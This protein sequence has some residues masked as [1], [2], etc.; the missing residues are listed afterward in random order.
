MRWLA[1]LL[2]VL[3]GLAS[4]GRAEAG[5][6]DEAR[7]RFE[8]GLGLF[9]QSAW[10]EALA[11][12]MESRRLHPTRSATRN[13]AL[14]YRKL[15]R[16]DAALA[17]YEELLESQKLSGDERRQYRAEA[18]EIAALVGTLVVRTDEAG[19][20]ISIDGL[21][22]GATPSEPLRVPAGA[23]V[24]QLYKEGYTPHRVEVLVPG[25]KQ[26][27]VRGELRP[28]GQSG[29][30]RISETRGAVS[31]VLVD[32]A[33]VGRTPWEGALPVGAHSVVLRAEPPLGTQPV[34][35]AVRLGELTR[36]TV[37][38]EPLTAE[39]RIEP[40]PAGAR[41]KLD[42]VPLGH[43]A[44]QGRV[45]KGA[46]LVEVD[47]RG[48]VSLERRVSLGEGASELVEVVLQRE[49][50]KPSAAPSRGAL[51]LEL[52]GGVPL[53]ASL[54]G[55][56]LEAPCAAPCSRSPAF[57]ALAQGHVGYR[58]EDG[59]SLGG[60]VGF[61][62]LRQS[63]SRRPSVLLER[64][65][66]LRRDAGVVD[67]EVSAQAFVLGATLGLERG[68]TLVGRGRLGVGLGVGTQSD[69]RAGA[70]GRPGEPSYAVG[71]VTESAGATW[72]LVA[73]EL[74]LGVRPTARLELSVGVQALLVAPLAS[75]RW[76][77]Q[78]DVIA[79]GFFG[80]FREESFGLGP[81]LLLVP[82][83]ALAGAL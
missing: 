7:A 11:E 55:D 27:E 17:L 19:V 51:T 63:I 75:A 56:V 38:L 23:H 80:F 72:A 57:G 78:R 33:L 54:A 16:H 73:P 18:D 79:S 32:G 34:E 53:G 28:L 12:F 6:E 64:P 10:S 8:R 50:E 35:A 4:H 49:A 22:R 21:D 81:T 39:L 25:G 40:T 82:S 61:L 36:L 45:R 44:W 43:G 20:A 66:G 67:D 15:G 37:S 13:A 24:L 41:V 52:L 62:H 9:K 59:L 31:E 1:G 14:C 2:C 65:D 5:P 76:Q 60:F 30:L 29:R 70:F 77:N 74:R 3:A 69:K 46:H 71:P 48:Y 47:A 42:G 58:F 83:L 68:S 26:V